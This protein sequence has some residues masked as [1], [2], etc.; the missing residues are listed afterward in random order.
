MTTVLRLRRAAAGEFVKL[1]RTRSL[2]WTLA[3]GVLLAALSALVGGMVGQ[4]DGSLT[5]RDVLPLGAA[6]ALPFATAFGVMVFAGEVRHGTLTVLL[7]AEP[8]RA[9]VVAAKTVPALL[10]G[11]LMG[12]AAAALSGGAVQVT[13]GDV[14]GA[15]FARVLWGSAAA[16]AFL[17]LFGLGLAA[18]VRNQGPALFVALGYQFAGE[19]LLR[20]G[21]RREVADLAE[22]LPITLANGLAM[23]DPL[24][25]ARGIA[26]AILAAWSLGTV[27]VG[28]LAFARRDALP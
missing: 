6:V 15:L 4:S 24:P 23:G 10:G 1:A 25:D 20:F 13:L 5:S 28:T 8:R 2:T 21:V 26:V 18:L 27:V 7:A 16:G 17:A 14:P 22:R 19:E 3:A 12:A 9:V 11:A